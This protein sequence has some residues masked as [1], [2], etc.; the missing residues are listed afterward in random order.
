MAQARQVE[1]QATAYAMLTLDG[2][3]LLLPQGDIRTLEPLADMD[4]ASPPDQGVGWIPFE[5]TQ[6]PMYCLSGE[7]SI[8]GTIP[9][10]R[11]ICVLLTLG[12]GYFGLLCDGL[13]ALQGQ[14]VEPSPLPACMARPGSP[15]EALVLQ[16]DAMG[17]VSGAARLEAFLGVKARLTDD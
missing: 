9:P 3:R 5:G 1:E 12:D 10:A 15:I 2:R 4:I 16:G 8:L 17:L 11:R 7:L 14:A 13:V 6:W